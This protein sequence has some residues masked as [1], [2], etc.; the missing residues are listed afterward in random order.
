MTACALT[1]L[2]STAVAAPWQAS[3]FPIG[4]WYGPPAEYNTRETW[5][6]VKDAGFTFGGMG[7]YGVDGNPKM[8]DLCAEVGLKAIVIDG[9]LAWQ[10]TAGDHWRETLAEVVK[11]YGSH[12]AL[13]GYYLQDE[14]H[15]SLFDALGKV[16]QELQ[17][18]DPRHLPYINLF[19]T[20]ASVEQLGNPTFADHLETFLRIVQP[21]VLSYDHYALLRDGGL[22]GDYFENLALIRAAAQRHGVAPWDIFLSLPHLGYRDPTA[23]EMR[24][25]AYT[26][27]AYGM[28]GLMYFT[29]WTHPDWEKDGQTAIVHPDGKP[30]RLYPIVQAVNREVQALGPTLLGLTST[31]VYHTG[32]I[33]AACTRLEGDAVLSVEGDPPLVIGLFE[34]AQQQTYAMLVNRDYAAAADVVVHFKPHV[35]QVLAVSPQDGREQPAAFDKGVL[36]LHLEPGDGRLFR[37]VTEFAY[38]QPPRAKTDIAFGF[39]QAD[40]LDGWAGFNSLA[41]PAVRDGVLTLTFTGPDPFLSRGMLRIQP[42]A[43][44]KLRVRMRLGSGNREGQLFWATADEPE[45]RDDK[46][47]NFA[48][49][50][51]GEWHEYVIPVGEHAKWK[52]QTIIALRLDPT[53]GDAQPGSKVDIDFIRGE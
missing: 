10:V 12:P 18:I 37:L 17:R 42:D 29:Y 28:K 24:W 22:R 15:Y 39:D 20:Y 25:Q 36:G 27:L 11:D 6:A 21:G 23:A 2:L 5:Q 48:I 30:A 13:L 32:P 53:T 16:S 19:P 3:E 47:L 7:N 33:P 26:A 31:A 49:Q 40:D 4:Y 1:A 46:Y 34:D 9:R 8:L 38:A 45:F 51:D 43:Y 14:P 35:K 41:A 44:A 50:P 52:G